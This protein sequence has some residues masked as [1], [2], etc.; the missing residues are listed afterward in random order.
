MIALFRYSHKPQL[1]IF[2]FS[3]EGFSP[4]SQAYFFLTNLEF[5]LTYSEIIKANFQLPKTQ[6]LK[7]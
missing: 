4:F 7:S 3:L 6:G 5:Q 1:I 2:V